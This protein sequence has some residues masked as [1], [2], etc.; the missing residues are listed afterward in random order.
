MANL[1][2][3]A[4]VSPTI[5]IAEDEP[6]ILESL[7]FLLERRGYTV[8]TAVDSADALRKIRGRRPALVVLDIMMPHFTGFDL[9]KILRADPAIAATK[10]L[11]LTAK[12]QD[13]DRRLAMELGADRY[14]TKPFANKDVVETVDRLLGM[15][16]DGDA[17]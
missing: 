6:F 16:A 8:V 14:I 10:V 2:E 3:R 9:L 15:G 5:L 17:A 12:G 4:A 13:A 1:W 7:C 11:V